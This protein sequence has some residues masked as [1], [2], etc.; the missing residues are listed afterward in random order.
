V[1]L[2]SPKPYFLAKLTFPTTFVVDREN[3]EADPKDW[4]YAPNASGP[5]GLKEYIEEEALIFE[6]NNAYHSQPAIDNI[7][8]LLYQAG[9]NLSYFEAGEID[10]TYI[11]PIDAKSILET[12]GD[13]LQ[14]QL[15]TTTSMCT[16]YIQFSNARPPLDDVNVRRALAL[17]IDKERLNE[18]FFEN[19]AL[20]AQSLLPPGMPGYSVD[21]AHDYYDAEAARAAL[22][23]SSYA[24][25]MPPIVINA[26]GYGDT[27]S[28]ILTAIIDMWRQELGIDVSVEFVDPR[29]IAR[30]LHEAEGQIVVMGWCADY[31]D[32][33][34]F[35]DVLSH[36]ESIYNYV[37]YNNPEVDEILELARVEMDPQR[38]IDDYI[39][40][41]NLL[42]EDVAFVPL[43]HDVWY[44]LVSPRVQGYVETPMGVP[45]L[46]L[47]SIE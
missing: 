28:P 6:R 37:E 16:D 31:P 27:D 39:Q 18:Q 30:R 9:N 3:I 32:P 24:G 45:I 44:T 42:A 34:N 17:A 46:H 25:N 13:P 38:R 5:F 35:L 36:S 15:L 12:D 26:S 33:E 10:V 21:E 41:E 1:V 23:D 8:Y 11:S 43:W 19:Q 47:L 14:D 20:I 40:V 7:V 2:D 29:D 4:V 22:A